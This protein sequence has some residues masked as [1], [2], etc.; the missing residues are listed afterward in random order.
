MNKIKISLTGALMAMADSVPGV[1][2]GTIAYIMGIYDKLFES[3]INL[4]NPLKRRESIIFLTKLFAGWIIGAVFA[5]FTI[6][7]LLESNIYGVSSMFI[8]FILISIPITFLKEKQLFKDNIKYLSFLAL[9]LILV[10]SISYLGTLL[11]VG[12]ANNLADVGPGFYVYIFFSAFIAISAMLLPG[13][14]GSTMLI[15]FGI[16]YSVLA[17]IH[18]TLK[19]NFQYLPQLF[20]FG[21]GILCGAIFAIKVINTLLKKYRAQVLYFIQ[22]LMVGSLYAIAVGPKSV[23]PGNSALN[24]T[25]FSIIYF[26]IGI[27]IIYGLHFFSNKEN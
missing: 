5:V 9:G 3:I 26:L 20:V 24:F 2:G 16:Y 23:D 1:S 7:R 6:T 14:S 4:T 19:L 10:I 27:L 11:D 12:S 15:I 13:V 21:L 25:N 18:E 22:G 17:A 8:G